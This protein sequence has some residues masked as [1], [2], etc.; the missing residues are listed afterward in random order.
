MSFYDEDWQQLVKEYPLI[1]RKLES[2]RCEVVSYEEFQELEKRV[3][4]L[5]KIKGKKGGQ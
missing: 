4:Q 5:E 2:L 3:E 1:A